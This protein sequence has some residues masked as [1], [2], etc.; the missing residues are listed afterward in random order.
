MSVTVAIAPPCRRSA[1]GC[2]SATHA[3]TGIR[4]QRI[5]Q[6]YPDGLGG[7]R[8]FLAV[9]RAGRVSVAARK[10]GVEHTTVSRRLAA[11]ESALGAPLFHRT[12]AG[13]LPTPL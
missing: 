9:A 2:A 5:V 4:A 6:K 10:L 13:Y 1:T 8:V 12:A 3:A 11:L 7:L